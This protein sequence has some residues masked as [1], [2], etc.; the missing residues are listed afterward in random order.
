MPQI[1]GPSPLRSALNGLNSAAASAA[2]W[3]LALILLE[4]RLCMVRLRI[5]TQSSWLAGHAG[6]KYRDQP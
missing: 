4:V 1:S 6:C 5:A 2:A 3:G